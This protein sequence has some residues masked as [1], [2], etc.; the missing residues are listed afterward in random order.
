[1]KSLPNLREI[2]APTGWSAAILEAE[3]PLSL[4]AKPTYV[5]AINE[6]TN[7]LPVL[8]NALAEETFLQFDRCRPDDE[9]LILQQNARLWMPEIGLGVWTDR[10]VPGLWTSDEFLAAAPGELRPLIYR[11]FRIQPL[12]AAQRS[13]WQLL[14]GSGV[15]V[16]AILPA[17]GSL[18]SVS[19]ET[20]QPRMTERSLTSYPFYVP[21]ITAAAL[22]TPDAAFIDVFDELSP[23]LNAYIRESSEDGGLLIL[24]RQ[25][26]ETFRA[27]I[28]IQPDAK[29]E[30]PWLLT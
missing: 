14:L 9:I 10:P 20:L 29:S 19:T 23:H 13:A 7:R 24:V 5:D 30:L 11:V 27:S 25:S 3:Y 15:L 6:L 1:L 21:L 28:D 26:L 2:A 16:R 12:P 22:A 17:A 4:E 18:V 8:R